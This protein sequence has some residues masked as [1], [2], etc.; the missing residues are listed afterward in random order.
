MA[1][2]VE[3][4][5]DNGDATEPAVHEIEGIVGDAKCI[6]ERILDT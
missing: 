4:C 5:L 1:R 3:G 6:D 2:C